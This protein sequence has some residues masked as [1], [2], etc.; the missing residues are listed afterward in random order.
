MRIL[1]LSEKLFTPYALIAINLVLIFATEFVGG[2]AYF[3]K[4]GLV[5]AVALIFVG[6]IMARIFTDY[7]F[8]DHIL[9]GF[10]KIQLAFFLFLGLVHV[11]EYFG[12]HVLMLNDEIIEL[13]A[14]V[15]Y[16]LWGLGVLLALEFV[17][18]I[19]FKKS[20]TSMAILTTLLAVGSL[21]L[22]GMNVSSAFAESLPRWLPAAMIAIVVGLGVKGILSLLK[23]REIMPVFREYSYY[24][25]FTMV[26]L[27]LT[28]FSEY[29]EATGVLS[30]IGIS[31]IQNLYISHFLIYAALSLLLIGFGKLKKPTGIYAE[32]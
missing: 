23:I 19:Y 26:L 16:L 24:A 2:G 22:M 17:F 20:I 6:L 18:R 14:T 15:S 8:S 32:M 13:S 21:S 3:A 27:V 10:L 4:T 31:K 25:I 11:Y 30:V 12:L 28:T 1:T 5:H 29:F 9:K 7:A